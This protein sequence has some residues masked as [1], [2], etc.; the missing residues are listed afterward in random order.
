MKISTFHVCRYIGI[1]V[2]ALTLCV[3]SFTG[4]ATATD[5]QRSGQHVQHKIAANAIK[6]DDAENHFIGTY[7]FEGVNIVD[8]GEVPTSVNNGTFDFTN[9]LG[10]Y[11]GYAVFTFK[12]GST[13]T[14][15]YE[16]SKKKTD[17]GR[18]SV[19]TTKFVGGTGRYVGIKGEGTFSVKYYNKGEMS[20]VDWKD[21]I[22]LP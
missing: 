16:G 14:T 7:Q 17:K 19:G 22:S 15:Y 2:L 21:S 4:V 10:P 1:F 20:I 8:G 12:D 18:V 9:G 11:S 13:Y 5:L 3:I 6:I